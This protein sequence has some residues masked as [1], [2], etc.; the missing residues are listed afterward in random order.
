MKNLTGIMRNTFTII[1]LVVASILGVFAQGITHF[2]NDNFADL[3]LTTT[4]TIVTFISIALF[5]SIP[6]LYIVTKKGKKE[7]S[8]LIL[9]VCGLFG[10]PISIWSFFIWAMWM[11]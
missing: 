4:I 5:I 11:G 3:E 1:G 6:I 7:T 10:I 8:I 9:S 2:L